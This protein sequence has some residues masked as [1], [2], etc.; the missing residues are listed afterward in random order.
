MEYKSV[1]VNEKWSKGKYVDWGQGE[2]VA[3][4]QAD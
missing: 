1:E 3:I 4:N 2:N